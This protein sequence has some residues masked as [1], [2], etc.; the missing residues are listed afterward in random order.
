MAPKCHLPWIENASLASFI[1]LQEGL[2]KQTPLRHIFVSSA[3]VA[4]A[5]SIGIVSTHACIYLANRKGPFHG[6]DPSSFSPGCSNAP[7]TVPLQ[8]LLE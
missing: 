7:R 4:G 1:L 6:H 5:D 2:I 3:D 8:S